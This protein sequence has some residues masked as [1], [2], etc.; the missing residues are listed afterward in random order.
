MDAIQNM[1]DKFGM[2]QAKNYVHPPNHTNVGY[3]LLARVAFAAARSP[4][5]MKTPQIMFLFNSVGR[6][7]RRGRR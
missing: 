7:H 5:T 4:M 2:E 3:H 6:C 1:G